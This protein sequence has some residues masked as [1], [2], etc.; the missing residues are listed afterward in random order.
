MT[1]DYKHPVIQ[2]SDCS[3]KVTKEWLDADGK[4]FT[5]TLPNQ[6]IQFKLMQIANPVNIAA[7]ATTGGGEGTATGGMDDTTT[8]SGEGATA[9]GGQG[10]TAQNTPVVYGTYRICMK[11]EWSYTIEHLPLKGRKDGREVKYS[12]R[13]EEIPIEGYETTYKSD[14][15]PTDTYAPDSY[16]KNGNVPDGEITITNT[17]K[18]SYELPATGGSGTT[19]LYTIGGLLTGIAGLLLLYNDKKRRKEGFAS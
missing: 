19:T 8:G 10:T 13:V 1:E 7:D 18:P 5:P 16:D 11:S 2:V 15:N 17:A 12:Y 4:P 6:E 3:L 14:Y 9:G